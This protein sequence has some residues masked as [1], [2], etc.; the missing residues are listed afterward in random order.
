M[1]TT[2][3]SLLDYSKINII[4]MCYFFNDKADLT[5]NEYLKRFSPYRFSKVEMYEYIKFK[6]DNFNKHKFQLV[7][8]EICD[9]CWGYMDFYKQVKV[10]GEIINKHVKDYQIDYSIE[11]CKPL[12]YIKVH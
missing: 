2:N 3:T 12:K 6:T 5:S 9:Y 10:D 11:F 1:K 7:F 4:D 8:D